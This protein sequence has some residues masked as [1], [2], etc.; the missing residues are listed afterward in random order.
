MKIQLM[1]FTKHLKE[2]KVDITPEFPSLIHKEPHKQKRDYGTKT[3]LLVVVS[4]KKL[5]KAYITSNVSFLKLNIEQ[6]TQR[7]LVDLA[8]KKKT[9]ELISAKDL[10]VEILDKR[11]RTG[12]NLNNAK[13]RKHVELVT[14]GFTVLSNCPTASINSL[15]L[16]RALA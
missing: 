2:F 5:K 3:R 15:K 10:R 16:E 6:A 8:N 13:V 12:V 11:I 9:Q 7:L 4:S 1:D 14:E